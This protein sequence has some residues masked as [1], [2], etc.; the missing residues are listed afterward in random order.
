LIVA[1]TGASGVIYGIR[2]L[3][4]LRQ[5]HQAAGLIVT[6]GARRIIAIE[7]GEDP[8]RLAALAACRYDEDDL[9]APVASGSFLT[10]GMVVAPCSIKTLSAIAHSHADN[11]VARAADVTLKERRRLVL[12]VRETPLHLGHIELMAAVTR[13]GAVVMPPVP[14]FYQRPATIEELVD[15]TV[16]RVAD[17]FGLELPGVRRWP[18]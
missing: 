14:A 8:E 18:G 4:R 9:A 11:L 3:H 12:L 1:I 2:L 13:M 17:L 6:A 7:T 16:N 5:V 15:Q 10:R